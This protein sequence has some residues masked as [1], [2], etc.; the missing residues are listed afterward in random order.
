VDSTAVSATPNTVIDDCAND[1]PDPESAINP[2]IN[3]FIYLSSRFANTN[4]GLFN[5]GAQY[6]YETGIGDV[7]TEHQD[8]YALAHGLRGTKQVCKNFFKSGSTRSAWKV[9]RKSGMLPC[10]TNWSDA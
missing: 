4:Q 6:F 9:R 5:A 1:K 10:S 2:N 8:R 7:V 3:F